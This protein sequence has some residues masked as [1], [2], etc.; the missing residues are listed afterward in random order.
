MQLL[1]CFEMLR[2]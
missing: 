2:Y 1:Q